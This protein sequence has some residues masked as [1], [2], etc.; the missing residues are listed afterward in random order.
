MTARRVLFFPAWALLW[1]AYE[2]VNRWPERW[3]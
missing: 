2:V 3:Y 1:L